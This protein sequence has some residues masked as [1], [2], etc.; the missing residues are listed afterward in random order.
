MRL[1]SL[2]AALLGA[3]SGTRAAA[4]EGRPH[5]AFILLGSPA[6]PSGTGVVS[7][8][9]EIAPP[10]E[11]QPAVEPSGDGTTV[12]LSIGKG[13]TLL[14]SMMPVPVPNHEAE[15]AFEYSYSSGLAQYGELAPHRAHL[16]AF[17]RDEPGRSR[18]DGLIR[19]TY[20][21]AALA[22]AAQAGAI[23]WGD[24]GAT[25]DARFFIDRAREHDPDLMLPL[26]C[27]FQTVPDGSA[28]ASMLTLGMRRQLG[29]ME[30]RVTAPQRDLGEYVGAMFDFLAYAARRGSPVP[31]GETIGRNANE[32]LKVRHEP[33]PI[34]PKERVWRVDFP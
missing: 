4:P 18:R 32:R 23:Y 28:R 17:F 30:L 1:T 12:Q 15:Q 25:H 2:F 7:A 10:T 22:K 33:S 21:L 14:V 20:L 5:L 31:E 27:G 8:F 24:S 9:R 34:D 11:S 13:G 16:V 26:W 3:G 29:M 6:L 19:F